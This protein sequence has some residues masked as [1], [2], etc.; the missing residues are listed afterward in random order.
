[1][2]TSG[3]TFGEEVLNG[4]EAPTAF[5]AR[6]MTY[7]DVFALE[8]REIAEIA[9][10]FPVMQTRLRVAGCRGMMKD[11]MVALEHAW[12]QVLRGHRRSPEV[13]ETLHEDASLEDVAVKRRADLIFEFAVSLS[14]GGRADRPRFPADLGG[15]FRA[16]VAGRDARRAPGPGTGTAPGTD[17]SAT[18]IL[19]AM[20]R[21]QSAVEGKIAALEA[22]LG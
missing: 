5:T 12:R 4:G 8:G 15:A 22:R 6:A 9:S 10:A 1:V 20:A 16:A 13:P 11:A 21:M 2:F 3:K 17:A 7:C 19:A 14:D 18:Q